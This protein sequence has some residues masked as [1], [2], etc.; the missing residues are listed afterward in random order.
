MLE[1]DAV[2]TAQPDLEAALQRLRRL[3]EESDVEGARA[4]VKEVEAQWPD[5]R[6]VQQWARVLE[7]PRVVGTRPASGRAMD[8]EVDWL[9]AHA[10]EYPGCW[11]ALEGERLVA[12]DP[13]LKKVRTQVQEAGASDVLLYHQPGEPK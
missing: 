12:A 6:R 13:D 3:V 11:L 8:R 7:P 5:D 10:R 9:K 2:P 1:T 4:Y